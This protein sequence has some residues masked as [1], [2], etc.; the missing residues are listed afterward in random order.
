MTARRCW[1]A[2]CTTIGAAAGLLGVFQLSPREGLDIKMLGV[3][4][5]IQHSAVEKIPGLGAAP[6]FIGGVRVV[7]AG[8]TS[9]DLLAIGKGDEPEHVPPTEVGQCDGVAVALGTFPKFSGIS[10]VE[11]VVI[12]GCGILGI[13][14]GQA[15]ECVAIPGGALPVRGMRIVCMA[16]G[17]L[18]RS[19]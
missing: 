17:A 3:I 7:M 11:F 8:V 19:V 9:R 14:D 1:C 12:L 6:L 13:Q 2:P 18:I 10:F 5:I 15:V 4:P 16:G